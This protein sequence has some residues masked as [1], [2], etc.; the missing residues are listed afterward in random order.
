MVCSDTGYDPSIHLS[1]SDIAVDNPRQPTTLRVTIKQSKSDP[2][3]D[4]F[5]GKTA[6]DLCPV[7]AMLNYLLVQPDSTGPLFKFQ[8]G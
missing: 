6:T 8:D 2:F 4:L 3:C 1:R 5:L 7:R